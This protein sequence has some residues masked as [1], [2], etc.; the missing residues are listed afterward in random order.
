MTSH[1][2]KMSAVTAARY[3]ANRPN[4][5]R[6]SVYQSRTTKSGTRTTPSMTT[7]PDQEWT[8]PWRWL[9][10]RASSSRGGTEA[11]PCVA[12]LTGASRSS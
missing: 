2:A 3:V 10:K 9:S 7:V 8:R 11:A 1:W 4:I 12:S 5:S 6:G